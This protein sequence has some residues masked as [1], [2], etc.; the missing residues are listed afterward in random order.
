[1]VEIWQQEPEVTGHSAAT[2]RKQCMRKVHVH[3]AFF[4]LFGPGP[5][6]HGVMLPIVKEG[7]PNSI[8]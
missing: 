1:M 2:I 4:F 3:L 5:R 8:I 6:A 7:L